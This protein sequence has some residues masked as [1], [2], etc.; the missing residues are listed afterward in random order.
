LEVCY[1]NPADMSGCIEK[2]HKQALPACPGDL[3]TLCE[4]GE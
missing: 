2:C 1:G 3:M 4:V